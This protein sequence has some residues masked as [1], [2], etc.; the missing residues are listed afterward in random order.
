MGPTKARTPPPPKRKGST[1]PMLTN[2]LNALSPT[3]EDKIFTGVLEKRSRDGTWKPKAFYV[4][5]TVLC[6][7]LEGQDGVED[8]PH[9][10][11][12]LLSVESVETKVGKDGQKKIK[13]WVSQ[14]PSRRRRRPV[15]LRAAPKKSFFGPDQPPLE[16]RETAFRAFVDRAR[17][18]GLVKRWLAKQN[19]SRMRRARKSLSGPSSGP[20]TPR[21]NGRPSACRRARTSSRS[22]KHTT[23][24]NSRAATTSSQI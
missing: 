7:Y 12:N 21:R 14:S 24:R 11:L 1:S 8:G 3:K 16:G 10:S 2:L 15:E 17:E 4:H 22:T 6:Y 23:P 20:P 9:A 13:L 5:G 19:P 18:N